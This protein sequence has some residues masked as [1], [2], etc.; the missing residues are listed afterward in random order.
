MK[1]TDIAA[2]SFNS[3]KKREIRSWLT[4]LGIV[5]GIA[6]VVSLLTIG[7]AFNKEVNA[8]L[9]KLGS[10]TVFVAPISS[11]SSAFGSSYQP[12]AGKLYQKDVERLKKI[13]EIVDIARLLRGSASVQFRDKEITMQLQGVEPGV[14]EVTT[15]FEIENGR[16]LLGSDRRVAVI[17]SKIANDTFGSEN[18]V[19]V[20]NYL[21]IN[22][23]KY[24]V[25]G[26]LRESGGGITPA[27]SLDSMVLIPF[28][29][30]RELFADKLAKDEI[31]AIAMRVAD[32]ADMASLVEKMKLEM[33]ASHRVKEDE[34]DYTV[35]SPDT[36]RERVG[37]VIALVTAFLGVVA[38]ISLIVGALSIASSMFTSV[39]E[40]THEIG[41]LR[42][43]GAD[44]KTV[45]GMFLFEAAA[46]G[47]IG[48]LVGA[49]LGMGVVLLAGQFGVPSALD[50]PVAFFGV[51]FATFIGIVS[52]YFP[53]RQAS[54]IS[55]VEALR[56]E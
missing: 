48:G 12:S 36:L 43:V 13:P 28:E 20:N 42:A 21:I 16:F 46:V 37:T 35:A 51:A 5:I 53:A 7:G 44:A 8:Q 55:P 24:R 40:R 41:V 6:A 49:L 33:D 50:F 32:G 54:D 10:S 52:G 47:G 56:Y 38:S 45:M 25:I 2:Y 15:S 34:R 39:A 27:G 22:G 1:L 31:H 26:V 18:K 23:Q 3:L 17:G 29:D 9:D 11:S 4:I 30:A 19:S 14:F